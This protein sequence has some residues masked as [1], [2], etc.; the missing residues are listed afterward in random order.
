MIILYVQTYVFKAAK[1]LKIREKTAQNC[2]NGSLKPICGN[3]PIG[4]SVWLVFERG[5][6]V[7]L[8][9]HGQ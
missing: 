9:L 1:L 3:M 4:V 6:P 8:I 7:L 2:G 5:E